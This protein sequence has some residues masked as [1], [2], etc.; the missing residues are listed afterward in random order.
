MKFSIVK[1]SVLIFALLFLIAGCGKTD[2][3]PAAINEKTDKCD[4]CHM[5]VKDDG[6]AAE[7]ILENEKTLKFDDIGCMYK[8]KSE[9]KDEKIG[10]SFI[11][12]YQTKKWLEVEK[13]SFVYD[14]SIKTPM[15]YNVIAFGDKKAAQDFIDKNSGELLTADDLGSH[16]WERNKTMMEEMKK[17]MNMKMHH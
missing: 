7:I 3:K 10:N 9:N 11:K 2:Y 14:K 6:F 13:A 5:A 15:A 12:D 17:K 16:S 1:Q 8:W 4:V